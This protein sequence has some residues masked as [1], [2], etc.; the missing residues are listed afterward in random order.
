MKKLK[1][2]EQQIWMNQLQSV[3]Y[4]KGVEGPRAL[5]PELHTHKA[6]G[7]KVPEHHI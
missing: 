3:S 2:P 7:P 1:V 6:E 5:D 4:G